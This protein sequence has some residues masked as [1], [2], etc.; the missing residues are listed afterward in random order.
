MIAAIRCRYPNSESLLLC[1]LRCRRFRTFARV[2]PITESFDLMRPKVPVST[3]MSPRV[4]NSFR[5]SE[6]QGFVLLTR[7]T[8]PNRA[9][10][11]LR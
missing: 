9:A 4:M 5:H 1:S 6:N 11:V 8:T 7:V 2:Q 3:P 10:R